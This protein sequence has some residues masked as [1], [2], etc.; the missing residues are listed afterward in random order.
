MSQRESLGPGEATK[1]KGA[2]RGQEPGSREPRR[3]SK[4]EE[5]ARA[6]EKNS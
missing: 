1:Q 6:R 4:R 3:R 2:R 5:R